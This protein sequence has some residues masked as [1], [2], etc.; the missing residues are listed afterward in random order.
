MC[1]L[2]G[3]AGC[4]N[5]QEKKMFRDMLVMDQVRGFDSTGV[6]S[7]GK[8][9]YAD[10]KCTALVEKSVGAAQNLWDFGSTILDYNGVAKG[11]PKVL[12]GHN[13][14]ATVGK[15]TEENAHPFTY[16]KITGAHNGSLRNWIDLEGA[17]KLDV[18]SKAIFN[19]IDVHGIDHT[20]KTFFGA[21]ALTFWD[22]E[23]QELNLV[24]N[25]E[26]PLIMVWSKDKR[27]LFWAS[28]LWMIQGAAWRH[29][30]DLNANEEGQTLYTSL[31][32]D[33]LYKFNVTMADINLK[34]E[35]KLEK[36]LYLQTSTATM[37][38]KQVGFTKNG[39]SSS[40][41]TAHRTVD[42]TKFKPVKQ[43]KD[44]TLPCD[45]D[46][47]NVE[48]VGGKFITRQGFI[49]GVTEHV[50]RFS[51]RDGV[52]ITGELDIYPRSKQE[53]KKFITVAEHLSQGDTYDFLLIDNPRLREGETGKQF[54]R[55]VGTPS[56]IMYEK[57]KS[58]VIHMNDPS[59]PCKNHKG[60]WV[61]TREM[62]EAIEQ[63][64][65]CCS[66]CSGNLYSVD[67]KDFHW[68]SKTEVLCPDCATNWAGN[69]DQLFG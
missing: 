19:D 20:W 63:A 7:V 27:V 22:D 37:A 50:F 21:A 12:L 68:L 28:E 13:R 35:R 11:L 33:T 14:A 2:V 32:V 38:S 65:S 60:E 3:V 18:D 44:K 69:Y 26:R 15:V 43:W 31:K 17:D 16:G 52:F 61:S 34:E 67:S 45:I 48:L 62:F 41:A 1:G 66:Y 55:Y 46:I 51:I 4:I 6:L 40:N 10:P 59:R 39:G 23:A 56:I 5:Q 36:K 25:D 53:L 54:R 29:K 47:N 30:V 42:V 58:N 57:V 8:D 64:G 9:K 24:R 49:S